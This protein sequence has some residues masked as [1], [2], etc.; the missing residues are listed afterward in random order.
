MSQIMSSQFIVFNSFLFCSKMNRHLVSEVFDEK[1][2][3]H[4]SFS[5]D[6]CPLMADFVKSEHISRFLLKV[7]RRHVRILDK[8]LRRW[9]LFEVCVEEINE[10]K[11]LVA[12]VCKGFFHSDAIKEPAFLKEHLFYN[13]TVFPL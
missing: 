6:L 8:N 11:N 2:L 9:R 5:R 4:F 10:R 7:W 3:V 1:D 13:L 12:V